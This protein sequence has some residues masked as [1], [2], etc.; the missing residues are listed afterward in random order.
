MTLKEKYVDPEGIFKVP[1]VEKKETWLT[2]MI[3]DNKEQ[4]EQIVSLKR[5]VRKALN[6]LLT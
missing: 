1:P 6:N 3:V 5:E 4:R 2:E